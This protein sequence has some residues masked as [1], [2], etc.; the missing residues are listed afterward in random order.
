[1]CNFSWMLYHFSSM[2]CCKFL[3]GRSTSN[4]VAT[5]SAGTGDELIDGPQSPT[6]RN[7][8]PDYVHLTAS[9]K[10]LGPLDYLRYFWSSCAIL[11]SVFIICYGIA[12][13]AYVLPVD[14]PGAFIIFLLVLTMLFYLEVILSAYL[15]C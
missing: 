15:V 5:N 12:N 8:P 6:E 2:F 14:I 1:M 10:P 13:H 3:C 9:D 4:Q 7:R 11:G